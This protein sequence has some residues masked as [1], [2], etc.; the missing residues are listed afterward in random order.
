MNLIYTTHAILP[1]LSQVV[2]V[3]AG[4][5]NPPIPPM[6]L[7]P[8]PG[9]WGSEGGADQSGS[10]LQSILSSMKTARNVTTARSSSTEARTRRSFSSSVM[11]STSLMQIWSRQHVRILVD[12]RT[13]MAR[14]EQ[15][16]AQRMVN[17]MAILIE[18]PRKRKWELGMQVE[19]R[20]PLK[21]LV[22]WILAA[23]KKKLN[24]NFNDLEVKLI[25][26]N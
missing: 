11:R 12:F 5:E 22:V 9:P 1:T 16:V 23:G 7:T 19:V 2:V 4:M 26:F 25:I 8:P 17:G 3:V 13:R 6:T 18:G 24:Q 21:P 15:A 14:K 10:Y 20:Q